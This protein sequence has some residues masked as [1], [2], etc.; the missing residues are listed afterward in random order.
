MNDQTIKSD[1][2]KPRL[3][4]VPTEIINCIARVR[5]FGVKKYPDPDSWRRVSVDR[6]RD[7]L[8]RHVIAYINN[9]SSVDA[10]SGLPHLWHIACNAAF[11][12]ELERKYEI[13]EYDDH[14]VS[15]LLED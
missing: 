4:L 15:G 2:G 9:P 5:E 13:P 8:F 14:N 3:S 12:C 1:A 7:A 6:Y 10:E 11:L